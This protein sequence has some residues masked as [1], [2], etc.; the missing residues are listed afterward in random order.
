MKT[1]IQHAPLPKGPAGQFGVHPFQCH[2]VMGYSKNQKQAKDFL[3]WFHSPAVY[4]KWFNV[5]K[6]FATGPTKDWEKSKMWDE[7][8]VMAPY[9]VAG[10]F[11][12]V[13]GYAGPAGQKAA[14]V[15]NKYIIVDMYAKAVQGMPAEDAVKWAEGEVKKIY[16]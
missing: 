15:L 5:Q 12:R 1:D 3:R 10:R 2:M 11:G 13:Y 7:D 8:P 14:E 9:R 6:G 16:G 4:E